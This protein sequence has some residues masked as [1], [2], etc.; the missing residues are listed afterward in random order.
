DV[1]ER[2]RGV[3][4]E[5]REGQRDPLRKRERFPL[6]LH[7]RAWRA[8][9]R[10]STANDQTSAASP[11]SASAALHARATMGASATSSDTI[12]TTQTAWRRRL[13]GSAAPIQ[14]R[15]QPAATNR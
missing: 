12:C 6:R 10:T 15:T 13:G 5:Q 4:D 3:Q 8:S 9:Q 1:A 2:Q 14:G 7:A 11:A